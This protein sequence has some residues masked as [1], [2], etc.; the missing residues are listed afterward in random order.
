MLEKKKSVQDDAKFREPKY[1]EHSTFLNPFVAA[2][3]DML[4]AMVAERP[5]RKMFSLLG[6]IPF[7][8]DFRRIGP[9]SGQCI[10]C[11]VLVSF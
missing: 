3:K 1:K 11:C 6:I 7:L 8:S 4:I 9:C 10:G 5:P 2:S